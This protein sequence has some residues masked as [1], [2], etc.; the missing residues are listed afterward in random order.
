MKVIQDLNESIFK[1]VNES[2][3]ILGVAMILMNVASKYVDFKF[4]KTQEQIMKTVVVREVLIFIIVFMGTRDILY[5]ILLTAAFFILSEYAFNE[6]SK[7]CVLSER[8]KKIHTSI[9]IDND[10]HISPEEEQRAL[11]IL[12]KAEKNRSKNIHN[13]IHTYLNDMNNLSTVDMSTMV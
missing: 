12:H 3:L 13:K 10:G 7:Y 5:S 2:K 6:K 11:D 4:S 9:D 1:H 8:M